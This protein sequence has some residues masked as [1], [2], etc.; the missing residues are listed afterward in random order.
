MIQ[1]IASQGHLLCHMIPLSQEPLNLIIQLHGIAWL[2][3]KTWIINV[4]TIG[5][6]VIKE[7][8]LI[9]YSYKLYTLDDSLLLL[10]WL[11][12]KQATSLSIMSKTFIS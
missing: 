6:G 1:T 9:I 3:L 7:R 5:H 12:L 4:T 11:S 10:F 2:K 8:E